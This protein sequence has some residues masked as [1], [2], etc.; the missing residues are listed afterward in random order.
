MHWDCAPVDCS[1]ALW[2]EEGRKGGRE[3]GRKGGREGGR[4]GEGGEG[5][6]YICVCGGRE[7]EGSY[8]CVGGGSTVCA[9]NV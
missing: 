8:I 7:G 6:S 5:E 9:C 4:E 2:R 1:V 3:E